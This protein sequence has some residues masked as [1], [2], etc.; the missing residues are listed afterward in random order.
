M[1]ARDIAA[2]QRQLP[3]VASSP[4]AARSA[5]VQGLLYGAEKLWTDAFACYTAVSP[6]ADKAADS[7]TRY[8][9]RV[10]TAWSMICSGRDLTDLGRELAAADLEPARDVALVGNVVFAQGMLALRQSDPDRLAA[11]LDSIPSVPAATPNPVTYKLAWR[12]SIR[13]F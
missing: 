13:A 8:R 4:D 3:A 9:L 11:A 7:L 12:G 1:L 2:V 10:L 5:L 6:A